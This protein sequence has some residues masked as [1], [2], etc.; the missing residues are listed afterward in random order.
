MN[1]PAFGFG[2]PPSSSRAKPSFSRPR[3]EELRGTQGADA[4]Y[5]LP[6][7][8]NVR[9]P[10]SRKA[11][12]HGFSFGK[13]LRPSSTISREALHDPAPNRYTI[14][15]S[16]TERKC[17]SGERSVA[18]HSMASKT[19]REDSRKLW[20]GDLEYQRPE[21]VGKDTPG[22]GMYLHEKSAI[23]SSRSVP[24]FS[25]RGRTRDSSRMHGG[26]S[27][28]PIYPARSTFAAVPI[29]SKMQR[30]ASSTLKCATREERAKAYLNKPSEKIRLGRESPGPAVGYD[31]EGRGDRC[32]GKQVKSNY[33]T[34]P[35]AT[36]SK[37][38]RWGE[39]ERALSKQYTPGPGAYSNVF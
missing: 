34:L 8:F 7:S 39:Y 10:D 6:S 9:E 5:T 28:G 24:A 21:L 16:T 23:A 26:A 1:A 3:Q 20:A 38:S 11:S 22:P 29:E 37:A 30:P 31:L 13:A 2:R 27:P 25:F 33:P 19:T 36:F 14:P 18:V 32:F 35:K 12:R 15:T 17:L 4:F